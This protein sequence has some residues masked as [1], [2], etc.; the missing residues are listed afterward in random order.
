[1]SIKQKNIFLILIVF[2]LVY[3]VIFWFPNSS[4]AKDM[5]MLAVFEP[6]EFAQYPHVI[7]M[8]KWDTS[9]KES[10]R[11]FFAYQ[12]YYYGFPFYAL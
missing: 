5:N 7:R 9:W 10:A 6:D 1:M 3:F 2:G 11:R 4:G 12:H 8:L